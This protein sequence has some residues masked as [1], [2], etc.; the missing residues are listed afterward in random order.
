MT[1]EAAVDIIRQALWISVLIMA[2]LLL[3]GL[4]VGVAVNVFQVATSLQDSVFSTLPRLVVFFGA[5]LILM[6]WMLHKLMAYT[7]TLF[8]DLGRYAK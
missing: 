5:F 7:V 6:P 8:S 3:T 4:I 1:P 2:P